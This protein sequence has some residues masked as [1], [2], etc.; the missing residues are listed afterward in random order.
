MKFLNENESYFK[1]SKK[2]RD[3]LWETKKTKN[4]KR[5]NEYDIQTKIKECEERYFKHNLPCVFKVTD[6]SEDNLDAMLNDRGYQ[7][8]TP[9]NLMIMDLKDK[10][11]E[12][13]FEEESNHFQSKCQKN[14][15]KNQI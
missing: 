2:Q 1:F 4:K 5:K 11:F 10:H 9:T 3:P 12:E 13:M 8:V 14:C 6:E 7:V 15:H